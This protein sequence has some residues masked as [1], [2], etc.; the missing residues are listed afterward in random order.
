MAKRRMPGRIR[1]APANLYV[2]RNRV[3][4]FTHS[5]ACIK[6]ASVERAP[7]GEGLAE[8]DLVCMLEVGAD[9]EA[10]GETGDGD[11]TA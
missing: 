3:R 10:T 5:A 7:A 2:S 1:I 11:L 4:R 9:W 8:S 6:I